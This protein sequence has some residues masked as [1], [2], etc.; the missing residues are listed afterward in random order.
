[1]LWADVEGH[2]L[3]VLRG[4][5]ELLASGRVHWLNLE[6]RGYMDK[7]LYPNYP[8]TADIDVYLKAYGYKNVYRYGVQGSY[9]EA[10]G[11]CIYVKERS[12]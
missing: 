10:P 3:E 5:K 9:P 1:L 12:R 6:T 7:T 11:D 2:E 8:T 4:G